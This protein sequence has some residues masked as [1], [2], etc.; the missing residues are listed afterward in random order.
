M[1]QGPQAVS[2]RQAAQVSVT[3]DLDVTNGAPQE[4][5]P[6]GWVR[7]V[8]VCV[9][10]LPPHAAPPQGVQVVQAVASVKQGGQVALFTQV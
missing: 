2:S 7:Q 1:L 9:P 5:L 6:G 4:G 8:R 3:Q 10:A